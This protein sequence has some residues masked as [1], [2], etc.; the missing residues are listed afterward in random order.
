MNG[1]VGCVCVCVHEIAFENGKGHSSL[2]DQKL[3]GI[4]EWWKADGINLKEHTIVQNAE[5]RLP[6]REEAVLELQGRRNTKSRREALGWWDSDQLLRHWPGTAGLAWLAGG[7]ESICP[8][9]QRAKRRHFQMFKGSETYHSW[10][11]Y[12]L[13][14]SDKMKNNQ[15]QTQPGKTQ[16]RRV[17]KSYC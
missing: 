5:R 2:V 16:S 6:S 1:C 4:F 8:Y 15:E 9:Y 10:S 3:W 11:C 7:H 17:C 14:V 12:W 13:V